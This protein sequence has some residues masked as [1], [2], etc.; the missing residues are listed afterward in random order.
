M[1]KKILISICLVIF[2]VCL[3][4]NKYIKIISIPIYYIPMSILF[5]YVIM[6]IIKTMKIERIF[7]FLIIWMVY[8]IILMIFN[9][10]N[11]SIMAVTSLMTNIITFL[12]IENLAKE[13]VQYIK[14]SIH[15]MEISLIIICIVAI[16]EIITK[17]HIMQLSSEY[18]RRFYGLPLTFY[19]NAND[20]SVIIVSAISIVLIDM[21]WETCSKIKT[22][23]LL[24]LIICGCYVVIM[25]QS[26]IGKISILVILV[27]GMFIKLY[28]KKKKKIIL[29]LLIVFIFGFLYIANNEPIDVGEYDAFS[30]RFI[31]WKVVLNIFIASHVV[32]IGPGQ[33]SIIGVGQVHC[34]PLEILS[35]YGI[36]IFLFLAIMYIKE[37]M[38]ARNKIIIRQQNKK[39]TTMYSIILSYLIILPILSISTSSMTKLYLTWCAISICH[40]ILTNIKEE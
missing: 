39:N 23:I 25:T 8:A 9:Y 16:Y 5:I 14:T 7:F 12:I 2:I 19:V 40:A 4:L 31:I 35:E 38:K 1:R 21:N 17:S 29:I 20:L 26:L 6:K 32:G 10:N 28:Y 34:L 36:I 13:D 11:S 18:S 27:L 3:S 15:A 30:S 22:Y 33:N 37:I 24:L